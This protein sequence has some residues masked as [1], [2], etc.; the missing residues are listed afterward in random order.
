MFEEVAT[1]EK[2]V[3]NVA[4]DVIARNPE[5]FIRDV[6]TRLATKVGSARRPPEDVIVAS[7]KRLLESSLKWFRTGNSWP[8]ESF[9]LEVFRR[10]RA[11]GFDDIY[12]LTVLR[13]A[14]DVAAGRIIDEVK[15]PDQL[16]E[17][18]VATSQWL[19]VATDAVMIV[20]AETVEPP[21]PAVAKSSQQKADASW[22]REGFPGGRIYGILA[23]NDAEAIMVKAV[24]AGLPALVV[25][26]DPPAKVRE[27][28]GMPSVPVIW[29]TNTGTGPGII[30]L[31]SV[32]P[33]LNSILIAMERAPEGVILIHG[34]DFLISR[35]GADRMSSF[36][37]VL[38]ERV[39]RE[40]TARIIVAA[41][42]DRTEDL[43][44]DRMAAEMAKMPANTAG[45]DP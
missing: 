1:K 13:C 33:L 28:I 30:Q 45:R 24:K 18:L 5:T 3:S 16:R 43:E 25:S 4:A 21:I 38:R 39:M 6:L 2:P 37:E 32:L 27:R 10:R 22:L 41:T 11:Q 40:G 35:N 9:M 8:M 20:M 42:G 12:F 29:M 36:V 26:R 23:R 31:T 7:A 44:M 17:A 15:D 34:M 19:D 14:R